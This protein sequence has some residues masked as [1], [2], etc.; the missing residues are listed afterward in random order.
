MRWILKIS[1]V[2]LA[3]VCIYSGT[4]SAQ[5]FVTFGTAG[6]TGVY[7]PAGGAICRL[8]NLGRK[9][10]GLRCLVESTGGSVQNANA[11]RDHTLD[12]AIVQSDT[13]A[14]SLQGTGPFAAAGPDPELRSLFSIHAEPV[15]LM[16]RADAGIDSLQDL[17]GKN[18]NIG[19]LGSGTRVLAELLLEY[20]GLSADDLALSEELSSTEQVPAL[21]D[22]KLDASFW[23]AGLPNASTQEAVSTCDIKMLPLSGDAVD[24]LLAE[25]PAFTSAVIPGGLYQGNPEDIPTWG[26]KATVI[27]SARMPDEAVYTIVSAVFD[28]FED[29]R[30]LHPALENL[31]P[32]DMIKQGLTADL[33]PGALKYYREKGWL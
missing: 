30:K 32:E 28:N 1:G 17:K 10:H 18:V 31:Q 6:V 16:V 29:F 22:G 21:C 2:F 8:V 9:D 25:N 4:A 14:A 27:T 13:Q 33:H 19:N 15:H 3:A 26:P 20:A 11:I 23:V 24:R 12:F 5:Q 7:Y